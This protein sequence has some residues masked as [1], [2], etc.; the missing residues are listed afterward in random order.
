MDKSIEA[1]IR[2]AAI[3]GFC[4]LLSVIIQQTVLRAINKVTPSSAAEFYFI[5]AFWSLALLPFFATLVLNV[6][7]YLHLAK[8]YNS[9]ILK[10]GAWVF[11]FAA[12]ALYPLILLQV[13]Q[14]D[15]LVDTAIADAL[16][17]LIVLPY[18]GGLIVIGLSVYTLRKQLGN[19][20]F[21]PVGV[22]AIVLLEVIFVVLLYLM[23][24]SAPAF[25][26]WYVWIPVYETMFVIAN[27]ILFSRAARG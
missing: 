7:G 16:I 15:T 9:G 2:W 11:S 12:A 10:A 22:G 18:I 1:K 5:F 21:W 20:V 19:V 13:F 27:I 3:F 14:A 8:K 23:G 26:V 24:R 25:A 4:F 17:G 6:R